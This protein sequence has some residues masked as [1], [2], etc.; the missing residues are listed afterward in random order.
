MC[1]HIFLKTPIISTLYLN[2]LVILTPGCGLNK[3]MTNCT[4]KVSNSSVYED[5]DS[6]EAATEAHLL[7]KINYYNYIRIQKPLCLKIEL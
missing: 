1:I 6:L 7:T 4:I 3:L 2:S 5:S